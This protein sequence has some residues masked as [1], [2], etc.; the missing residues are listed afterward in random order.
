[1]IAQ[2]VRAT[3]AQRRR[4]ASWVVRMPENRTVG[5]CRWSL[6]AGQAGLGRLSRSAGTAPAT[7]T[8]HPRQVTFAH[9]PTRRLLILAAIGLVCVGTVVLAL[10]L[11]AGYAGSHESATA[12]YRTAQATV[13]KTAS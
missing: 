6:R 7:R 3:V 11:L 13:L 9:P 4:H 12:G 10:W 8:C 2:P 5:L 1:R